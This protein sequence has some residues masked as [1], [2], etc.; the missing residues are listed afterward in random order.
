[1]A[2]TPN[3]SQRPKLNPSAIGDVIRDPKKYVHS[4]REEIVGVLIFIGVIWV[5]FA[6]DFIFPLDKLALVPRTLSGLP[7]IVASPFLHK[8]FGHILGNT[9]SL[10]ILLTL[11]AGSRARSPYI[12]ASLIVTSGA[13]LWLLGRNGTN[14]HVISHVGASG[15]VYGL[16]TFHIC[17]GI[18][19]RRLTS[20]AISVLVGLFYG[21]TLIRGIIPLGQ[22]GVSWDGHLFGAIAGV[23]VAAAWTGQK[24]FAKKIAR[25]TG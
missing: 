20:I 10:F 1:M 21:L 9:F 25:P 3:R 11:L 12:V 5:C 4:I 19:E 17:A 23:I 13:L 7:G 14:E 24:F 2:D 15:L 8:G 22:Y 6:L 18:F 16:I